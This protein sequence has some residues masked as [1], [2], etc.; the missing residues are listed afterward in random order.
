MKK[1][2]KSILG[3]KGTIIA[4]HLYKRNFSPMTL[5]SKIFP[6]DSYSDFFIYSP[7]YFLN[8]F[9][10]ENNFSLLLR[11]KM[12]VLHKFVFYEKDGNKFKEI[13]FM[14]SKHFSSFD[15]P[16]FKIEQKYLSFTHQVVPVD[17][18]I[19]IRNIL[20]KNSLVSF[21]HR[22]YTIFKKKFDSLG[23]T[24]H[25]NF[26]I[27][28]PDNLNKSACK[29]RNKLFCYTPC[30]EFESSSDY[31]L[32][33]NNPTNKNLFIKIQF[34]QK[35]STIVNNEIIIQSMGTDYFTLKGYKGMISFISKMPICR[36]LIF[37]NPNLDSN[38]FDVFHS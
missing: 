3:L 25:G 6:G 36:P 32:V 37:K 5:Y 21:Q 18:N 22:G 23:S 33:F 31:D 26:G 34:A 14:S 11:E 24:V 30:Y 15:L 4:D 19:K 2:L 7:R 16:R 9:K 12:E 29:Q 17:N 27:I 8:I 35:H 13:S 1:L 38:N 20:G 28:N 10:A